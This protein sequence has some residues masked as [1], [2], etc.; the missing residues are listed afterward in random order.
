MGTMCVAD[1]PR[2]ILVSV[3]EFAE[4]SQQVLMKEKYVAYI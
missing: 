2:T 3:E 1:G 4:V